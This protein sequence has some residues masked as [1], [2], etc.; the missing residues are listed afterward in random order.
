MGRG[1]ERGAWIGISLGRAGRGSRRAL[2]VVDASL[3]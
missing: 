1:L 3:G 2:A